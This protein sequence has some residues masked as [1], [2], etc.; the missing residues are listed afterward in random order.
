MTSAQ[1]LFEA[2]IPRSGPFT[3]AWIRIV[4]ATQALW[5]LLSRDPAGLSA[6]PDV[7]WREVLPEWKTRF[8]LVQGMPLLEFV[9]WCGAIFSL[10]CV[11]VGYRTRV[12]GIVG[13]LLLYHIAPLL[14][15]LDR[16][17]PWGK[18]LTI[19]TLALVV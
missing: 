4:V 17:P 18:G 9:L 1:R 15:L 11:L 3:L 10:F 16:T 7:I 13:A 6:M 2:W 14:V 19:A 5:I 12:F 8:F